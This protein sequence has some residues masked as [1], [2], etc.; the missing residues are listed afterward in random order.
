MIDPRTFSTEHI[1]ELS[2]KYN[3]DPFFSRTNVIYIRAVRS[4]RAR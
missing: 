3:K 4:A 1:H 2:A